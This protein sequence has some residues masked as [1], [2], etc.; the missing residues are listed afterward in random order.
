ML[1]LLPYLFLFVLSL[2]LEAAAKKKKVKQPKKCYDQNH[3]QIPCPPASKKTLIIVLSV[4]FGTL[5]L[6]IIA[7]FAWRYY[8]KR[9]QQKSRS[10]EDGESLVPKSDKK[11]KYKPLGD[12]D[13]E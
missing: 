8:K 13:E 1:N 9:S 7:Y 3:Q 12:S 6:I 2:A 11:G 5:A 10:L 4:I